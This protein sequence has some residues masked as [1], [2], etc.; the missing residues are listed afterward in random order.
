MADH[1][2]DIGGRDVFDRPRDEREIMGAEIEDQSAIDEATGAG[3]MVAGDGDG[4]R[5]RQEEAVGEAEQRAPEE[6]PRASD[7]SGAVGSSTQS[8][9]S[10]TVAKGRW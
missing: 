5:D 1:G 10:S 4:D 9:D 7:T 6:V 8:L 2:D 3:A